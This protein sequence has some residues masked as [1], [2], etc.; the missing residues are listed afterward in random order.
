[1]RASISNNNIIAIWIKRSLIYCLGLFILAVGVVFSVKSTLGV[2]PVTSV[3]NVASLITGWD[4]GIC[5]TASYFIFI[6]VEIIILRRDFEVI[7]W[8]QIFVSFLFGFMVSVATRLLSFIQTPESYLLRM[9][10]LFRI[11]PTPGDGLSL[12]V[13]KKTKL[14]VAYCKIITD[15]CLVTISIAASLIYYRGL[16]GV[17]EG[18]VI[19]ALT[20]GFVMKRMMRLWQPSL[21]RFVG[22]ESKLERA[23]VSNETEKES[24]EKPKLL[25]SISREFGSGGY[26]IGLRLAKRLGIEFYDKQLISLEAQESGLS[27]TFIQAHEQQMSHSIVYDFMTA[28]YAMY[29]EGLPPLEKLFAAQGRVLRS[30]AASDKSCVI[31]GRCSDFFLYNNPN[32]FRVFIHAAPDYRI[33]NITKQYGISEEQARIDMEHTDLSRARY[34]QNFTGREWGSTKYYNLAIDSSVFGIERSIDLLEEAL[35]L[36]CL[37]RGY[38]LSSLI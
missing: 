19:S 38:S 9:V 22:R 16:V 14:P 8:L 11:L 26:E 1:M 31:V 4:L 33:K 20:V 13:S 34:Y 10:F 21:L 23:L 3:A 6:I 30:I 17:R 35:K 15:C 32:S 2:S 27:E 28:G 36:W 29:N 5:T 12:A 7:M 18:T 24:A 37:E 25:I